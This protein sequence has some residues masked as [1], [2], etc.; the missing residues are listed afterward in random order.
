MLASPDHFGPRLFRTGAIPETQR[1]AAWNDV[2]NGWLLGVESNPVS[3]APFR[4][5]ACLRALP[6][7]RFGRG[8]LGGTVNRR[9]RAMAAQDNDDLFLFVNSGGVFGASQRGRDTEVGVGG[10]YL[11]SCAEAGTYRWPE[12]MTLTVVRT[13]HDEASALV[14]NVYDGMGRA[15]APDND[16]LRLL[17]RYLHILHDAE[18]L[19][20]PEARAL[21][22]RHVQ[23][24]L[25]LALGATGDAHELAR[26]RG[27]RAARLKAI[28][29]H[30][31]RNLAEPELS[32]ETVAHRFH[33]SARTLQRHFEADGTSFSGYVLERRLA[34]VHAA[35]GDPRGETRGI[36]ELALAFGFGNIS[37][38]NRRFRERYGA[39][40]SDI[41]NREFVPDPGIS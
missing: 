27:F 31:E 41:R 25:A 2:V 17:T 18:P 28:Q 5:S 35:L 14:R 16:G 21:V 30:I 40:P 33:I 20:T 19:T 13:K 23:D 26:A 24:L 1:F 6:D 10:A 15:L 37:Y 32:P 29:A 22:T 9:T 39:A 34:Q 38:F 11:M 3:D 36:A 12:G 7:L 4:G 8:I